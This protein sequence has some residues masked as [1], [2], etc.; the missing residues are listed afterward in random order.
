MDIRRVQMTGGSSYVLTLP[1]DWIMALNI[2]KNDPVGVMIQPDGDLMITGNINGDLI[3]RT[4]Q[5]DLHPGTDPSGFF[6]ILVGVY[7]A[8]YGIIEIR[9]KDRIGAAVRKTIREFSDLVIGLEPVEETDTRIILR[10][11][12]NPLEMPFENSFQRMTVIAR[13]MLYD[14]VRALSGRDRDLALDVVLRDRDVDRLYWLVGRQTNILLHSPRNAD[15]VK[16]SVAEVL[17]YHQCCKILERVADHGVK[18][19]QSIAQIDLDILNTQLPASTQAA[20]QAAISVFDQSANAF[21]SHDPKQANR[22]ITSSHLLEEAIHQI[23]ADILTLPTDQAMQ[24]RKIS[25]SIRR[26]GEY[27]SDLGEQVINFSMTRE[28]T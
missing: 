17:H 21:L 25:D 20:L 27:S 5:L 7:I 24:V 12:F 10:D 13:G 8:G 3:P 26:I 4:K 15:R 18:I 11:L 1:K 2:R 23:N 22:V 28:V 14:G 9:S 19:A 6:R 16:I